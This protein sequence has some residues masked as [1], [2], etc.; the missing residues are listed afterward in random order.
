[1]DDFEMEDV[2]CLPAVEPGNACP[3]PEDEQVSS[4]SFGALWTWKAYYRANKHHDC[5]DCRNEVCPG[6][7]YLR[8]AVPLHTSVLVI[9]QCTN[10]MPR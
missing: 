5:T 3:T 9:V 6:E 8:T 4:S 7:D 10:C 2:W 1:M